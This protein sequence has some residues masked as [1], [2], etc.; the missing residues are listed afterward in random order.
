[1]CKCNLKIWDDVTIHQHPHLSTCLGRCLVIT[2]TCQYILER[3]QII[4]I[5]LR[6]R[7]A[8]IGNSALGI[9]MYAAFCKPISHTAKHVSI[10]DGILIDANLSELR[11]SETLWEPFCLH[12]ITLIPVW[13]NYYI[14]YK[15][16]DIIS[17]QR[18][19]FSGTA[20]WISNCIP[21]LTGH[22]TIHPCWD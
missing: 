5:A 12:E 16:W 18:P 6:M 1:M 7:Y 19:K 2:I 10:L 20:V 4:T 22:V 3:C 11:I 14:H 21:H 9:V 13:I 15:A 8:L 17:Y